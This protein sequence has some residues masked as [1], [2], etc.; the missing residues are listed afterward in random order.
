MAQRKRT[1]TRKPKP[2][3]E[4]RSTGVAAGKKPV[5]NVPYSEVPHHLRCPTC[6]GNW[7]GVGKRKGHWRKGNLLMR[8]YRCIECGAEWQYGFKPSD[9]VIGGH[10]YSIDEIVAFELTIAGQVAEQLEQRRTENT[11]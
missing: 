10:Y 7:G 1:T 3:T 9:F 11:V 8:S 5:A 6:W 2:A 4:A